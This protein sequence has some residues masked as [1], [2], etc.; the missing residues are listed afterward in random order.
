MHLLVGLGNP[1]VQY[2]RTRHNIGFL[3]VDHLAQS[4]G[5]RWSVE[6][7]FKAEIAKTTLAGHPVLL[8]KPQTY[9]NLSGES[10]G[11]I[12][13]YYKVELDDILIVCDEVTLPFGR[14][15]IRPH[16]SDGGQNGMKSVISALGSNQFARL[17]VGV[18][19]Q[20][21]GIPLEKYVLQAFS[22]E[23]ANHLPEV[24]TVCALA[25]TSWLQHGIEPTRNQYNGWM[26]DGY[27]ATVS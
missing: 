19:P 25:T 23:E 2:E 27:P 24:L 12:A 8:V 11:P 15:R 14:L 10:V 16:G 7:S 6:K 13:R 9:M 21:A 22:A 4:A 17:R 18:G 20:P 1:G 26:L 3:L 5:V